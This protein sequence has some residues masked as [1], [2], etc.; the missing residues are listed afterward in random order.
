MDMKL[1][2]IGIP[3]SDVGASKAFYTEQVGF[4]L[5]RDV[6]PAPGMRIVQMTPPR[7]AVLDR[8]RGGHAAR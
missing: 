1:E 6:A 8:Q 4:G 3:V 2:V 5:D 7:L